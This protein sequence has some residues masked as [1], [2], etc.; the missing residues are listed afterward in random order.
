MDQLKRASSSWQSVKIHAR[1]DA[2]FAGLS[3]TPAFQ[4]WVKQE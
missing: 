2:D 1:S 4:E 3:R